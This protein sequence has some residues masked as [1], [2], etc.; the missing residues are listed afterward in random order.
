MS[1][2][3]SVTARP[4]ACISSASRGSHGLSAGWPLTD[5]VLAG[6]AADGECVV[7]GQGEGFLDH[8]VDA[9]GGGGFDDA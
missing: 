2:R 3:S 5:S 1:C 9:V 8:G 6:S 4:L 7:E